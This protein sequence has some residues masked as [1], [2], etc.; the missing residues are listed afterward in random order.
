MIFASIDVFRYAMQISTNKYIDLFKGARLS[1]SAITKTVENQSHHISE[2]RN[3]N[4]LM[5]SLLLSSMVTY[6]KAN[7]GQ[8]GIA[9]LRR[10]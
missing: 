2:L 1:S 6:A 8:A 5:G 10:R 4:K 9:M 7:E 3:G